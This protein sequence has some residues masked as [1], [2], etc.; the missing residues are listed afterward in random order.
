MLYFTKFPSLALK[1]HWFAIFF[2][3]MVMWSCREPVQNEFA[4]F[5]PAPTLNSFLVADSLIKVHVSL[6]GKMDTLPLTVVDQA[7]VACYVNDS[8]A[9]DLTS[10]GNGYYAG[11]LRGKA[12]NI[13]RF[14]VSIPGF[15]EMTA[16][17]TIPMQVPLTSIEHINEAGIDEEGHT[18]PAIRIIFPVDPDHVQFFQVAIRINDWKNNWRLAYFKDFSDTVMLAEGL[19]IAVFSSSLIKEKSY[20]LKLDYTIGSYTTINEIERV[21]LYPLIVEFK[22]ISYQYYQYL[23]QLY[24]YE[25]GRYPDFS[26]GPLH[27]FPLYSNVS[28][29]MG[30]VA[31]YSV[32]KSAI[33]T[34]EP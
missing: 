16:T 23:R 3:A 20:T 6:A 2:T 34:P 18:F 17:D 25:S 5:A 29:G 15:P 7:T 12:G 28:N 4:D 14:R 26:F 9:G 33:I 8:M 24:L 13:Y 30:I 11:A 22:T 27:N 10:T 1:L 21:N 32:F 19:P 31:G